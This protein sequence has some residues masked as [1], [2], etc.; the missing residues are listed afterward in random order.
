MPRV[1]RRFKGAVVT[2]GQGDV[3]QG[4]RGTVS[5]AE[6]ARKVADVMRENLKKRK[7]QEQARGPDVEQEPEVGRSE[8]SEGSGAG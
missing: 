1:S 5:R 4:D 8:Q 2:N 6:R 7:A 3:G